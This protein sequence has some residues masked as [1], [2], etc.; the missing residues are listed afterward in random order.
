MAE[1]NTMAVFTLWLI[2]IGTFEKRAPGEKPQCLQSRDLFRY[3]CGQ[4]NGDKLS[5]DKTKLTVFSGRTRALLFRFF[6]FEYLSPELSRNRLK[7]GSSE[8]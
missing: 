5:T 3:F 6:K 7:V 8:F 1:T 2:L 4:S